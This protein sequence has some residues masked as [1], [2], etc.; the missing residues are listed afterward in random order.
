MKDPAYDAN[1]S[2]RWLRQGREQ[3]GL[4]EVE[5]AG[6]IGVDVATYV[7]WEVGK[8]R[9][10]GLPKEIKNQI[11]A[12]LGKFPVNEIPVGQ[13]YREAVGTAYLAEIKIQMEQE[14][15]ETWCSRCGVAVRIKDDGRC[16]ECKRPVDGGH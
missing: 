9:W 1:Y 15:P 13:E 4:G 16:P 14:F 12:I 6:L 2:G 3:L 8:T 7:V 10:A 5:M 11:A